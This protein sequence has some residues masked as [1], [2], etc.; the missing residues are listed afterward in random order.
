[1]YTT[2]VQ[3]PAAGGSVLREREVYVFG[4]GPAGV[5]VASRLLER[6]RDV[7]ILDC[8]PQQ[9]PWGGESFTGAIRAPL[10]ALGCWETFEK[11]GHTRGY[12]RE[13]AW[14]GAGRY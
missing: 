13:S 5:A 14:G 11:A 7:A 6:G 9:K 4:G 8:P 10:L 1:M 2:K 12:E 3:R